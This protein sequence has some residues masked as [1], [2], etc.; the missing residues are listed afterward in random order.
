M[1]KKSTSKYPN[2]AVMEEK[3]ESSRNSDKGL[4][5]LERDGRAD[6]GFDIGAC[7]FVEVVGELSM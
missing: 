6:N 5:E 1:N 7:V 4:L 2:K 3:S